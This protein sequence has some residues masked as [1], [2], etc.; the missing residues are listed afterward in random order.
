MCEKVLEQKDDV[1]SIIRVVDTFT[2]TVPPKLPPDTKPALNLH[3]LLAFKKASPGAA[4]E[5]HNARLKLHTPSGKVLSLPDREFAFKPDELAGYNLILNLS[6]PVEEYGLFWL[7]VCVD[8]DEVITR[9]PFRL[10][11]GQPDSTTIH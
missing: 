6:L 1:L 7:D 5:K 3:G 10:L 8:D 11:Q 2:V 9:V 4:A